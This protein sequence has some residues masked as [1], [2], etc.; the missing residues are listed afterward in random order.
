MIL[1][2]INSKSQISH[3]FFNL[4][5]I[6]YS[7]HFKYK[8][9]QIFPFSIFI[10]PA[11]WWMPPQTNNYVN[12]IWLWASISKYKTKKE[13]STNDVQ[14]RI[15]KFTEGPSDATILGEF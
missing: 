13:I 5:I 12:L 14:S 15:W 1:I 10:V 3:T 7:I 4:T 6:H 2:T 8:D 9:F 11:K